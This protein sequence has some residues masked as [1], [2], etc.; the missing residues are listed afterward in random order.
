LPQPEAGAKA[1]NELK[2]NGITASLELLQ[3][4]VTKD[5]EITRAVDINT[6]RHGKLD[7]AYPNHIV[8][9]LR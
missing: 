9:T 2:K 4:D 7:G 6:E 5:D 1:I 3:L 8:R